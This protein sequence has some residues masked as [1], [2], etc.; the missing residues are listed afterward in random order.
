MASLWIIYLQQL[1]C[2]LY[3]IL[4]TKQVVSIDES[5]YFQQHQQYLKKCLMNIFNFERRKISYLMIIFKYI[6]FWCLQ[7]PLNSILKKTETQNR[8][9]LEP[10]N[11]LL[12]LKPRKLIPAINSFFTGPAYNLV[13]QSCSYST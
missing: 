9:I 11:K 4:Q 3:N 5:D 12:L 1:K 13:R 8:R 6:I 7:L 2:L 10:K